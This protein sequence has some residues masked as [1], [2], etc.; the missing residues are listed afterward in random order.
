MDHVELKFKKM[1]EVHS[2]GDVPQN[3]TVTNKNSIY[4]D[5]KSIIK[6]TND[7]EIFVLLVMD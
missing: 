5:C 3:W 2:L 1:K 4:F 6:S 7:T